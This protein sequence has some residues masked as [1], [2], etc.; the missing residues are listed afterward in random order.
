MS[1]D[2]NKL[3][4]LNDLATIHS[5]KRRIIVLDP[6]KEYDYIDD[7]DDNIVYDEVEW[8]IPDN[9][10]TL[11]N[12]L[13]Q[14]TQLSNEDKILKI[15]EQICKDYIYDDNLISY[16]QKVDFHSFF[17]PD[18]YARKPENPEEWQENREQHN[19]RVCYEVSRM[20]AKSLEELFKDE[21]DYG[22]SILWD[23]SLTH[24]FVALTCN[25]YSITLDT[26]DFDNIKDLTRIK[27]DLTAEGIVVLEDKKYK[28]TNALD[29]FNEGKSKDAI[30][31][32]EHDIVYNNSDNSNTSTEIQNTEQIEDNDD[33]IFLKNAIEILK[34]KYDIDSQGLFE[35]IKEI[36]DIKL[37]PESRTKVWKEIKGIDNKSTRYIRC[38]VIEILSNKY[39]IDVDTA[40]LRP[41]DE[42]EFDE[43]D[44][45]LIP[46]K[47]LQRTWRREPYDG[48]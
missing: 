31:K 5:R 23:K 7:P 40:V 46:Y 8:N 48:T 17:L 35:Y 43:P 16:I 21:E 6:G 45:E 20:L 15:Y 29:K 28:F 33:I 1:I 10:Q 2:I 25:D 3:I 38:L 32:I 18:G 47:D 11:V 9:I 34:N 22:V 42:K 36:V 14:S 12:N 30:K 4:K 44:T 27:S 19:R 39:L 13:S 26:D 41:F 37:G 24:Y